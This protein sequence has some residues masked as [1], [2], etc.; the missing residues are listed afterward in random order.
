MRKTLT[1]ILLGT[2]ISFALLTCI[3]LILFTCVKEK[4]SEKEKK[5]VKQII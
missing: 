5:E 2:R 1:G 3:I 4:E